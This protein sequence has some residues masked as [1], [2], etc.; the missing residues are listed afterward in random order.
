MQDFNPEIVFV[1][2]EEVYLR[3]V[4]EIVLYWRGSIFNHAE[5]LTHFYKEAMSIIGADLKYFET[6]SMGGSRKLK[7]NTL[8]LL[9][10]WLSNPRSR[11]SIYMLRLESGARPNEPSDRAFLFLADEEEQLKTGIIR[12]V[13][14]FSFIDGR[15]PA[16]L[17]LVQ[18]LVAKLNFESGH[19]GYSVNWDPDGDAEEEALRQMRVISKKYPGVDVNYFDSTL[20]A[21][22]NSTRPSIKCV[23]WLTLVGNDIQKALPKTDQ[24]RT[25]SGD[26]FLLYQLANG[27]IFQAGPSPKLGY[28]DRRELELYFQVGSLLSDFRLRNHPQ[29]LP[30]STYGE[31][32]TEDWLSRFD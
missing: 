3:L 2:N 24:L 16:M 17:E 1:N 14:P 32:S 13:L 29:I 20:I 7:A 18:R 28:P 15:V 31:N 21:F 10:Y 12:L 19:A 25:K 11:R 26:M 9:P 8:E 22:Q 30:D 6:E 27:L 4:T 5:G 23:N